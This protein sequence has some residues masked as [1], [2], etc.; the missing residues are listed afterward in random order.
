M[1]MRTPLQYH[2]AIA[3]RCTQT[4]VLQLCVK[5]SCPP[6]PGALDATLVDASAVP[7]MQ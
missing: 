6:V 4:H 3:L 2:C 1:W 5:L 7:D